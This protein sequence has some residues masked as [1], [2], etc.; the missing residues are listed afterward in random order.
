MFNQKLLDVCVDRIIEG[1]LSEDVMWDLMKG[2]LPAPIANG[3]SKT[4][5]RANYKQAEKMYDYLM[6]DN[7]RQ[8]T[9]DQ[10]L[11]K[12]A[13]IAGISP[14]EFKQNFKGQIVK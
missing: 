5:R 11:A 3:L 2:I 1:S 14:R 9:H 12:A 13:I 6:K 10:A 8:Y 4:V 7:T